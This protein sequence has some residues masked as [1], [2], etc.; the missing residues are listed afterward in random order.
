MIENIIYNEF[1]SNSVQRLPGVLID[2]TSLALRA[3]AG[4]GTLD[5]F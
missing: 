5:F 1:E 4:V 3:A 2:R